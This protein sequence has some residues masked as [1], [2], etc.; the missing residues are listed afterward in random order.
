VAAAIA[1][2]CMGALILVLWY[3]LPLARLLRI[4]R[5]TQT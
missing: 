5:E 3:T 4:R 2:G 1:S